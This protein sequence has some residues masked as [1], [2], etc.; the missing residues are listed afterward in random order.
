MTTSLVAYQNH[1]EFDLSMEDAFPDV[2]PQQ[3][4]LGSIV[5]VQIRRPKTKTRGGIILQ[6]ETRSTEYYR[7]QV[8]K[9]IALGPLCFKNRN[10]GADWPEGAWCKVGDFVYVP[11]H[12]GVRF[13]VKHQFKTIER[14]ETKTEEEEIYF[15]YLKDT[16]LLGVITG[17]PLRV[18]AFLD[19]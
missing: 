10:D 13:A 8:A 9:V 14:G 12:G 16:N 2:S 1:V 3:R 4:P 17:D 7:T 15:L 6:D 5:L 18:R 11:Q 19:G